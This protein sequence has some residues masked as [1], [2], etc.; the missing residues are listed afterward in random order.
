MCFSFSTTKKISRGLKHV[1]ESKMGTTSSAR[2]IEDV[3]LALKALEIV[4]H[5]NGDAV[6]VIADRNGHRRKVLG[7]GK[8]V[9][10]VVAQTKGEGSKCKLT[11]KCSSAIFLVAERC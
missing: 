5:A 3:N 1:W 11:K 2:I 9:S 6:E 7:E 10:W 8:S 4:F